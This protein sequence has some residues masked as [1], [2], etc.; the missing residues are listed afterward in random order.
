MAIIIVDG[1]DCSGKTTLTQYL[2]KNLPKSL[3][4]KSGM[5]GNN[6]KNRI[7]MFDYYF[8]LINLLRV[9]SKNYNIIVDR[10]YMSEFS[11]D[12]KR[13]KNNK[14]LKDY[15]YSNFQEFEKLLKNLNTKYIYCFTSLKEIEKKLK[16]KNDD[17]CNLKDIKT[18]IKNFDNFNKKTI[19]NMKTYSYLKNK[20]EDVLKW[21]LL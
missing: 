11:Y 19:L 15:K 2:L 17:Y 1:I 6:I 10:C 7:E 14:G 4:L 5:N 20:R 18:L 21:I 3:Y 12:F 9:Y 16:E 8:D 13:K